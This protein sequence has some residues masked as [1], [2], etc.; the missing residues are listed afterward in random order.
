MGIQFFIY[1]LINEYE[2]SS[3]NV[4]DYSRKNRIITAFLANPSTCIHNIFQAYQ[5]GY[6]ILLRVQSHLDRDLTVV[7]YHNEKKHGFECDPYQKRKLCVNPITFLFVCDHNVIE[8]WTFHILCI[9][10]SLNFNS[11]IKALAY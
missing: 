9:K 11:F 5:N 4:L 3:S 10:V 6:K 2:C 1:L 7:I 8:A